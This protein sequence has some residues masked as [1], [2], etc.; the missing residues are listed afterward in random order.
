MQNDSQQMPGVGVS[1]GN[2]QDLPVDLFG[3]SEL[4]RLVP[5][6]SDLQSFFKRGHDRD[7]LL[8]QLT[9]IVNDPLLNAAPIAQRLLP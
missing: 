9:H 5:S 6:Q 7:L 8:Q 2:V 3:F 4:S 1:R